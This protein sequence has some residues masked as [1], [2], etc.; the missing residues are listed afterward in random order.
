M[1]S[2]FSSDIVPFRTFIAGAQ[3]RREQHVH[4]LFS[5]SL[6]VRRLAS[7]ASP[8]GTRGSL[9]RHKLFR[10]EGSLVVAVLPRVWRR[11]LHHANAGSSRTASAA[12]RGRPKEV[13]QLFSAMRSAIFTFCNI[14]GPRLNFR[15]CFSNI[16]YWPGRLVL[17]VVRSI[18]KR[19]PTFS[20][21]LVIGSLVPDRLERL[22]PIWD[23]HS[24]LGNGVWHTL[25]HPAKEVL[26]D[27]TLRRGTSH[28]K[29][30]E[31]RP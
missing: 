31:R 9:D 8:A 6:F 17:R 23:R 19:G 14:S 27:A 20:P 2:P 10:W 30:L 5:C 29:P 25:W 24:A 4:A 7:P 11:V 18:S 3:A 12:T 26:L 16:G 21:G 22:F 1:N 15:F 28:Q 13:E